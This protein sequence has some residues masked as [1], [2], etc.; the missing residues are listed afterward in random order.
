M[1]DQITDTVQLSLR[2]PR[3]WLA[4]LDQLALM[5]T[6]DTKRVTTR[7][8]VVRSLIEAGL[9]VAEIVGQGE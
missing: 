9:P 1:E 7:T 8:D 3:E 5:R 4:E 2:I 6:I